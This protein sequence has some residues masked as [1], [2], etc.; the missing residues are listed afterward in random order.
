MEKERKDT[1]LGRA[2]RHTRNDSFRDGRDKGKNAVVE[3]VCAVA[4]AGHRKGR[5]GYAEVQE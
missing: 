3:G 4:S 5:K 2:A 1:R